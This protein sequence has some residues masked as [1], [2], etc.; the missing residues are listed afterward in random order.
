VSIPA[1]VYANVSSCA[2]H[3]IADVS[4][5]N[6]GRVNSTPKTILAGDRVPILHVLEESLGKPLVLGTRA[7]NDVESD[8]AK[9]TRVTILG[10]V[11]VVRNSV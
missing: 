7:S 10:D 6:N 1:G 11:V 5:P 8:R 4:H 3:A 2:P 9:V